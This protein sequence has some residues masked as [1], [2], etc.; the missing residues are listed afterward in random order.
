MPRATLNSND[1]RTL[2]ASPADASPEERRASDALPAVDDR[3]P[4]PPQAAD[5]PPHAAGERGAETR[6]ATR[7]DTGHVRRRRTLRS[8]RRRRN[9]KRFTPGGTGP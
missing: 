5:E 9:S 3:S 4:V 7:Q 8:L 1:R 6:D 2:P